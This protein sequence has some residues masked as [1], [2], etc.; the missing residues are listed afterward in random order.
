MKKIFYLIIT[1]FAFI[2]ITNAKGCQVISGNGFKIGDEIA[3]GS[4]HFYVM[5]N[6]GTY[7]KMLA[8]YNLLVESDMYILTLNGF[9]SNHYNGYYENEEVKK[10]LLEGYYVDSSD[11]DYDNNTN[12]YYN[13]KITLLRDYYIDSKAVFFDTEKTT[14]KEVYND[15]EIKKYLNNDYILKNT[16]NINNKYIGARL[17]KYY[18]NEYEYKTIVLDGTPKSYFELYNTEEIKTLLENGYYISSYEYTICNSNS[19]FNFCD[20]YAV[21]LKKNMYYDYVSILADMEYSNS[22]DLTEYLKT[23]TDYQKYID[24]GYNYD[25][26]NYY[27]NYAGVLLYKRISSELHYQKEILQDK[28]AIGSHGVSKESPTWPARGIYAMSYYEDYYN[29]YNYYSEDKVYNDGF[30]DVTF[31]TDSYALF[32][33]NIYKDSLNESGYNISN[34]DLISVKELNMILK[35]I[36]GNELPLNEYYQQLLELW[37]NKELDWYD[38]VTLDSIKDNISTELQEKYNW[39]WGT[40]YWTKTTSLMSNRIFMYYVDTLGDLCSAGN[41]CPDPVPVGLRPVVT[42]STDDLLYKIETKTDGNGSIETITESKAGKG[43]TFVVTPNEGYTLKEVKVTDANGNVLT[44]KD[45][46]FT[47]PDSNVLIEATFEVESPPTT[48]AN[49]TIAIIL[50]CISLI[51]ILKYKRKGIWLIN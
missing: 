5:S 23:N 29:Y 44:F 14:L 17:Y 26:Y 4:E 2:T 42:I 7:V 24:D 11:Y 48:T 21:I 1:F 3:C 36:T 6:D 32:Y 35:E 9:S 46:T 49:I 15:E 19:S 20:F 40:T 31:D 12:T 28:T 27:N 34:I 33:L 22:T 16:F 18:D 39:L 38:I 45:Y 37:E 50:I 13:F 47:M 10:L 30:F 43:V 8:K 41:Y 25:Y 51:I